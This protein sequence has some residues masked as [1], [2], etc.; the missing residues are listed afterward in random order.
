M[1]ENYVVTQ[2]LGIQSW[3][4]QK[5]ARKACGVA[6]NRVLVEW[7]PHRYLPSPPPLALDFE[8]SVQPICLSSCLF[9]VG[10]IN[11]MTTSKHGEEKSLF[12]FTVCSP[13]AREPMAGTQGRSLKQTTEDHCLLAYPQVQG[14]LYSYTQRP[15]WWRQFF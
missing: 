11:T 14:Q 15:V 9:T 2:G 13:P 1:Q 5:Q 12:H 3:L 4:G 8:Q 10:L 6:E 7:D